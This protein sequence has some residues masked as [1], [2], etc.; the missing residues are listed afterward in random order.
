MF[1]DSKNHQ[2][3]LTK[4]RITIKRKQAGWERGRIGMGTDEETERKM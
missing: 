3:E 1:V 2:Q 4:R